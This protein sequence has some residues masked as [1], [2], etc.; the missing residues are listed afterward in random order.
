MSFIS[1]NQTNHHPQIGDFYW[2]TVSVIVLIEFNMGTVP[3]V[4]TA[5]VHFRYD[6]Y[7]R[8]LANKFLGWNPILKISHPHALTPHTEKVPLGI[9]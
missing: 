3:T 1:T 4:H 5:A 9:L 6:R 7:M 8:R 2:M